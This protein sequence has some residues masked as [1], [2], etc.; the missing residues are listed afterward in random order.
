MKD[1][2]ASAKALNLPILHVI[3]KRLAGQ[4]VGSRPNV[5]SRPRPPARKSAFIFAWA[6]R[7]DRRFEFAG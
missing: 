5:S 4:G 3:S 1:W 6:L 2:Q 7:V